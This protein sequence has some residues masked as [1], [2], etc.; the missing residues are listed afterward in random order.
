MIEQAVSKFEQK[1]NEVKKQ[2]EKQAD[3]DIK[4]K[5]NVQ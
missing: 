3:V 5:S 1:F 4:K 2:V